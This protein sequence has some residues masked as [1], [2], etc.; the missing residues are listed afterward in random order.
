MR[1]KEGE[2][3]VPAGTAGTRPIPEPSTSKEQSG[4][5]PRLSPRFDLY[6]HGVSR[7]ACPGVPGLLG[8][9]SCVGLVLC[10]HC[11]VVLSGEAVLS[12]AGGSHE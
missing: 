9:P 2:V 5:K 11:R 6:E 12:Q 8:C 7:N 3:K 4:E 10:H 1:L